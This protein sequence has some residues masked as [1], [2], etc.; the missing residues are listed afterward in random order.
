MPCGTAHE[1][2]LPCAYFF[3]K[4]SNR[5]HSVLFF[6]LLSCQSRG[7]HNRAQEPSQKKSH[8]EAKCTAKT[9]A[10]ACD[11][12]GYAVKEAARRPRLAPPS[13]EKR[14]WPMWDHDCTNPHRL[15]VFTF[16]QSEEIVVGASGPQHLLE[17]FAVRWARCAAGVTLRLGCL[18]FL[19]LIPHNPYLVERSTPTVHHLK[20]SS[21]HLQ[22]DKCW[23]CWSTEF[24]WG[25]EFWL[26]PSLKIWWNFLWRNCFSSQILAYF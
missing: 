9:H 24:M 6:P 2:I 22:N 5:L 26:L 13:E 1:D 14:R 16:P 21:N 12:P 3:F 19:T 8:P 15:H 10:E 23:S 20:S 18:T 25:K 11:I 4:Q 17:P 7:Q